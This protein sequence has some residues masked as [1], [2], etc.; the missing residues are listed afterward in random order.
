MSIEDTLVMVPDDN[1]LALFLNLLEHHCLNTPA[2]ELS[3]PQFS[4]GNFSH[5]PK[6]VEHFN[7]KP[8]L[9]GLPDIKN[10]ITELL[11]EAVLQQLDKK[12][13]K[14]FEDCF[15]VDIPHATDLPRDV[16]HNIKLKPGAPISTAYSYLCPR[17]YCTGWKT[18]IEQYLVAGNIRP[19]SLLYMSP[20][21]IIP[22][23][24]PSVLP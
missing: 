16:Y 15:P 10:W 13:K 1:S 6:H 3:G 2:Y 9:V 21:F 14:K 11:N 7:F 23:S 4:G 22:K 12:Y 18:L 24:D 19:S 8:H 5:D 20:S 17:K